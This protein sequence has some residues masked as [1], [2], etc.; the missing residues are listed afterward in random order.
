MQKWQQ[1]NSY[2]TRWAVTTNA[3]L[4]MGWR[5]LCSFVYNDSFIVC[6][7]ATLLLRYMRVRY[8]STNQV[9]LVRSYYHFK[10]LWW[11]SCAIAY[12]VFGCSRR[13]PYMQDM[14]ITIQTRTQSCYYP[15]PSARPSCI[16]V[17]WEIERLAFLSPVFCF[18]VCLWGLTV[19]NTAVSTWSDRTE[20]WNVWSKTIGALH[21]FLIIYCTWTTAQVYST[22]KHIKHHFWS[23][24]CCCFQPLCYFQIY[25][26]SISSDYK[27]FFACVFTRRLICYDPN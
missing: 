13:V 17:L 26:S 19:N 22:L 10:A 8:M 14:L 18:L 27:G 3:S 23:R 4:F 11:M 6:S 1:R 12:P 9:L 5:L 21:V 25:P 2:K 24:A 15:V 16:Y 20:S 7:G